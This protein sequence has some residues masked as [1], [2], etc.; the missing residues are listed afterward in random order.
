[1]YKGITFAILLI[2]F[3]S[4]SFYVYTKGTEGPSVI[5]NEEAIQGKLLFQKYNCQVCHQIYGLGGYLGPELTTVMSKPGFGE[6][7]AMA[8]LKSGT[9]RMP[10]FKLKESEINQLMEFLKYIDKTAI[11]Y[12]NNN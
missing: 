2:L 10:N 12:K 3:L 11:T 4:N 7:Y 1:M 6:P 9:Q 8:I 5:M